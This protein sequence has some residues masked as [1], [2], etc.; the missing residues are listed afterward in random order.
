VAT[1]TIPE[2]KFRKCDI[3]GVEQQLPMGVQ[4]FG[5]FT[6]WAKVTLSRAEING[7]VEVAMCMD[8]CNDCYDSVAGYVAALKA[9]AVAKKE[10]AVDAIQP[11]LSV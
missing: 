11:E 1:R 7:T 3:C 5:L 4:P 10:G 8:S 2:V 6:R 9:V